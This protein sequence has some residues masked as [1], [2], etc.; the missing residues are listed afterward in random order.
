M[1][2]QY[3]IFLSYL[4]SNEI[5]RQWVNEIFYPL[6]EPL[7]SEALNKDAAIF[8]DTQDIRGGMFWEQKIKQA[9]AHSRIM[10][11]IL[12]PRY[13]QSEWCMREF[14]VMLYRQGQVQLENSNTGLIVP[15]K[16]FD[17]EYFPKQASDIQILDCNDFCRIGDAMKSSQIYIDLQS[18]LV[19]WVVDVATAVVNAPEWDSDWQTDEWLENPYQNW[20]PLP[21]VSSKPPKL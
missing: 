7:V 6:F 16:I 9:L 3:D 21:S 1:G 12:T 13:F 2:Y 18:A 15:L 5:S 4:R 8:M 10:V 14:T 11:S 20:K 19:K 17:G